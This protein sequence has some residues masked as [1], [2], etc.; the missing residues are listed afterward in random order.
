MAVA[1]V[2]DWLTGMRGGEKVLAAMARLYPDADLFTLVHVPGSVT[3]DL[4]RH[5]IVTPWLNRLPWVGRY[6]RYLL[7]LMPGAIESL[8]LRAYDLVLSSSHCVAKGVRKGPGALH[9]CYCHSP[10]R[11]AWSQGQIY[12]RSMG[13]GGMGLRVFRKRLRAWDQQTAAG[14]DHFL[15]NSHNVACRIRRIY[16]RESTIVY[17][18][19][20]T[21]FFTPADQP[22][23]DFYL[24]VSAMAPYKRLDQAIEAMRQL[25]DRRLVI[26]GKGQSQ[27]ALRRLAPSNVTF[28][29][30]QA[31]EVVRE[32][33][34]RA[35]ALLFPGEEDFGMVPVEAMACGCPVIAYGAGGAVETVVDVAAGGSGRCSGVRYQPQTTEALVAAIRRFEE[36]QGCFE[37]GWIVRHAGQFG[38]ACFQE[39]FREVLNDLVAGGSRT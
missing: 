30:W 9:V 17:P 7:P 18:P 24:V 14:V 26:I 1:L 37:G 32:H 39:R 28:L 21:E 22:R 38:A 2:H 29:G 4:E 33:Y 34:R 3:A 13:L 15:A 23:E 27:A 36:Q 19:I 5:R 16:G 10:M 6:Y 11:Y 12:R 25:R 8:D 31:D 20:D 35:R